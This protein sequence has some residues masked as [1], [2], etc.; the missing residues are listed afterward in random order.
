MTLCICLGLLNPTFTI[1]YTP[2]WIPSLLLLFLFSES[3][4]KELSIQKCKFG[5]SRLSGSY[6][7]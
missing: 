4:C 3:N 1:L 6:F 7:A 2:S 5:I